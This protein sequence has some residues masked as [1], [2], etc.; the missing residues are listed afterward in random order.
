MKPGI[1]LTIT[2]LPFTVPV[3]T[4]STRS[5]IK[6]AMLRV[7]SLQLPPFFTGKQS[8]WTLQAVWNA[9]QEIRRRR[10]ESRRSQRRQK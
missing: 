7:K 2:P 3:E 5:T 8:S 4:I 6:G 9:H 10:C 1:R